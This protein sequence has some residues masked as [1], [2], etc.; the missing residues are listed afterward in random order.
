MEAV[1]HAR[2]AG[3]AVLE[4]EDVAELVAGGLTAGR[5][6]GQVAGVQVQA[7]VPGGIG[8]RVVIQRGPAGLIA[9]RAPLI[10]GVRD[11]REGYDSDGT[12][13]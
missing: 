8:P 9:G 5:R 10:E 7:A 6:V 11:A 4:A 3:A 13:P 12:R 1:A 2:L